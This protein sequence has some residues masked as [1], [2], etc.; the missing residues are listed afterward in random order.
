MFGFG[1]KRAVDDET[2]M[3]YSRLIDEGASEDQR[4]KLT[5]G[6][7]FVMSQNVLCH[8][9]VRNSSTPGVQVLDDYQFKFV[10][11]LIAKGIIEKMNEQIKVKEELIFAARIFPIADNYKKAAIL[12]SFTAEEAVQVLNQ[13]DQLSS[14]P[15]AKELIKHGEYSLEV[16]SSGS[17][18]MLPVAEI[19]DNTK[20]MQDVKKVTCPF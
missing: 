17:E 2:F 11:C 19:F 16:F 5:T 3:Y 6:T 1:K 10:L 9:I 20:L 13:V 18:N 7:Q 8:T 15:W 14:E 4:K 12:F